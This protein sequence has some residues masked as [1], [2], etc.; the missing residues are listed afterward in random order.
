[1]SELR[2]VGQAEIHQEYL[3]VLKA[4]ARKH[5]LMICIDDLHWVDQASAGLL[6]YIAGEIEDSRILL[7]GA[8]RGEEIREAVDGKPHALEKELSEFKRQFGDIWISMDDTADAENLNFVSAFLDAEENNYNEKFRREFAEHT[9]GHGLFVKELLLDMQEHGEVVRGEDG[10]W[11]EGSSLKWDRIPARVE[12]VIEKRVERLDEELL[13][14][15]E[16]ASVEG[17]GFTAEV[18][19]GVLEREVR[20]IIR[21]FSRRLAREHR[22]IEDLGISTVGGQR[23]T[24][25][26]FQHELIQKYVYQRLGESERL[27][28]HEDVG[29]RLEMLYREKAEDIAGELAQHFDAAGNGEKALNYFTIAGNKAS[30]V[31]AYPQAIHA[32]EKA[33]LLLKENEDLDGTARL[34]MTL[35]LTYHMDANY[36][37]SRTAYEEGFGL[38]RLVQE[39][40]SSQALA[41]APRPLAMVGSDFRNLDPARES[42]PP[43]YTPQIFCGLA[44]LIENNEIIPDVA[45]SWEIMEA[46]QKYIFHLRQDVFW[47]DGVKV[48]ADDFE[49]AW[50]RVLDPKT[51]SPQATLLDVIK[52]ARDYHSKRIKDANQV[53]VR[54]L[55][56][57]T[58][59][60]EL[61]KPTFYFPHI[62][63]KD[64]CFPV[65]RHIVEKYPDSWTDKEHF[66]CNGPFLLTSEQKGE[67]IKLKRNPKYHGRHIGNIQEVD[68]RT[69]DNPSK[70]FLQLYEDDKLDIVFLSDLPEKEQSI[71]LRRYKNDYISHPNL[72]SVYMA[73]NHQNAILKD[74]RL[75]RALA[76]AIDKEAIASVVHNGTLAPATGGFIPP[77]I[78]GHSPGLGLP[79]DP[80]EAQRLLAEAGYPGGKGFPEMRGMVLRIATLRTGSFLEEQWKDV[81]GITVNW[82]NLPLQVFQRRRDEDPDAIFIAGWLPDYPDGHTYLENPII[83]EH[84]GW[85]D[86]NYS[87]ILQTA[88]STSD[89]Q[90]RIKL[91]KKAEKILLDSLYLIPIFYGRSHYFVK[92][93]VKFSDD[94]Y[95]QMFKGAVIEV[96]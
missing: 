12:G 73:I 92:P 71:A 8:Y 81:L 85:W 77:G 79:Y 87:E 25:F 17:V 88:T 24:R 10:A 31:F 41:P 46:G 1:M 66:V 36:E 32:Y 95:S 5:P 27:L 58:L 72:L 80:S 63:A 21:D 56:E 47:S 82:E 49:F 19:A 68:I 4:I 96:N 3:R 78:A 59:E 53:G 45:E 34:L 65:P 50:K 33:L 60:V 84:I 38:M 9:D 57:F 51:Q 39:V 69:R 23:M 54:A 61:E 55:D 40:Q 89:V 20:S 7:V 43:F 26:R 52:G 29:L 86:E 44:E 15:L 74:S 70:I 94:P 37:S 30:E 67:I 28:L 90:R 91:Y 14:I 6:T 62:I 42:G 13:E 18:A 83:E 75:R 11:E 48:T 35:G 2:E 93:G 76:L 64:V 16:V 22:L